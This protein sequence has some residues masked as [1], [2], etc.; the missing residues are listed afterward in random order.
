MQLLLLVQKVVLGNS[1]TATTASKCTGNSAT[2]T[3]LAAARN[4]KLQGAVSGNAEF[5]GSKDITIITTQTNIAVLTGTIKLAGNTHED[6]S[7]GEETMFD[8]NF[9]STFNK[10]N[11]ILLSFSGKV[12]NDGRGFADGIPISIAVNMISGNT[13]RCITLGGPTSSNWE[14]KI[15]CHITN[16]ASSEQTYSYRIVL[17]KIA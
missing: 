12:K 5:D 15:R 1:A 10:E 13:P 3:K 14:N 4:I 16:Y 8:I 9:P 7:I 2:A 11:C 6:K 17:M